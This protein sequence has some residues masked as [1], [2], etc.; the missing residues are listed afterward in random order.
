MYKKLAALLI[1]TVMISSTAFGQL[2]KADYA[3]KLVLAGQGGVGL[4]NKM[5]FTAPAITGDQNYVWPLTTGTANYVLKTDGAGNLDWVNLNSLGITSIT[6][7]DPIH[8]VTVSGAATVSIDQ[9][10]L[11]TTSPGITI[12]GTGKTVDADINIALN[13]GDLTVNGAGL[14]VTGGTGSVIGSGA[15]ITL[16]TGDLTAGS[17]ALSIGNGTDAV[18]GSGA[19][20]TLSTDESL[21]QTG[22]ELKLNMAHDNTWLS[23]Q[24]VNGMNHQLRVDNQAQ[25]VIDQTSSF[26]YSGGNAGIGK[27]LSSVTGNGDAAWVD[28]STLGVSTAQGT[29]DEI[30][31]NGNLSAHGGP[32]V[33]TTPQP[34]GTTSN[35]TFGSAT[36]GNLALN[37]PV[38]SDVLTGKLVS[39]AINLAGGATEVSGILPVANGGT[40]SGASLSGSSI[41]VA[42]GGAI[43]Q[44]Q[45]GTTTTVLHGNAAGTPTYSQIV[46]ADIAATTI[47]N[48]KLATPTFEVVSGNSSLNVPGANSQIGGTQDVTINVN[49]NNTW[50]SNQTITGAS[51][52]LKVETSA[53]FALEGHNAGTGNVLT[54]DANG[55]AAWTDLSSVGVTAITGTTNQVYANGLAGTDEVGHVTLTLPQDINTTATVTFDEVI[56]TPFASANGGPARF[57]GNGGLFRGKIDLS[58]TGDDV[59][60][61]VAVGN[62]GTGSTSY[63]NN[64]IVISNGTGDA[65]ISG[66]T[67]AI[68]TVLH[69]GAAGAP[70]YGQIVDG[71]ITPGTIT[72][73]SLATPTF[74]VVSADASL[75][76]PVA[77]S[78]IGGNQNVQINTAH[79]NNWS[80]TQTFGATG[81]TAAVLALAPLNNDDF[82]LGAANT[83]YTI[84]SA[85]N[86]NLSGL[87]DGTAGRII[88][89][90]NSGSSYIT[91]KNQTASTATNQ[92]TI[93]G[94]DD[95]IMGPGATAT[96]MYVNGTWSLVSGF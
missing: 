56:L 22:G 32:I 2:Y 78:Q 25:L 65:L 55:V 60:G 24:A 23:V 5:T 80:G 17:D 50:N 26:A 49:H 42:T 27:I 21:V 73:G 16:T 3:T 4:P 74:R 6:G 14:G 37:Q 83:L 53:N 58:N 36:L 46:D 7:T 8:V 75:T 31:V 12:T 69:G 71:D 92:F 66:G 39:G 62:G 35:V 19:S 11:L 52:S 93:A 89:L 77:S 15:Q 45:A 28:L 20:V 70:T 43:V 18:V 54:S 9:G 64:Q 86:T 59:T 76:V 29:A 72:N 96:F 82:T 91:I 40:N 87:T 1:A 48:A 34:I 30:Y 10:S 90:H 57:D 13:T 41:M 81:N 94:G 84:S 38:R 47:T 88:T 85:A 63:A 61:T 79:D 33:L 44:G 95:A 51:H 67:G 68:T